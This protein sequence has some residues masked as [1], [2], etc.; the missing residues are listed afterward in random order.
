[1]K[2]PKFDHDTN[3]P[4]TRKGITVNQMMVSFVQLDIPSKY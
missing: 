4:G 2:T 3:Q 1:M